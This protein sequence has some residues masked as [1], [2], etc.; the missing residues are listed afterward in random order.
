M[1]VLEQELEA[2]DEAA[3]RAVLEVLVLHNVVYRNEVLDVGERLVVE[4]G[5]D[6]KEH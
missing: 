5:P 1:D 4:L 2:E 3:V 6:S